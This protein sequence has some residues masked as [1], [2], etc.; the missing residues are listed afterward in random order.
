MQSCDRREGLG[1]TLFEGEKTTER[2]VCISKPVIVSG[3]VLI[4][5]CRHS[6]LAGNSY[7]S[8]L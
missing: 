8:D 5:V 7:S 1:R 4:N 3:P 6:L 2:L